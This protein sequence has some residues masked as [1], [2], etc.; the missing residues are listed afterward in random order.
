MNFGQGAKQALVIFIAVA[1]VG[2]SVESKYSEPLQKLRDSM[3]D[4]GSVEFRNV[5]ESIYQGDAY[6]C[7]EV[8]AKNGFGAYVGYKRFVSTKFGY[9]IHIDSPDDT[10]FRPKW[11][12]FCGS[13]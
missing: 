8:N 1:A 3:K 2:C 12:T 11:N 10:L 9:D 6:V 7:G 4:P 5:R 13:N